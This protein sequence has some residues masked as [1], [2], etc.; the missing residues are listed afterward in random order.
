M[1][2]SIWNLPENLL[3]ENYRE[4]KFTNNLEYWK[5]FSLDELLYSSMVVDSP[6]DP[7]PDFDLLDEGLIQTYPARVMRNY[8]LNNF[9][10][11]DPRQVRIIKIPKGDEKVAFEGLSVFL[12][13][14]QRNGKTIEGMMKTGGY[15]LAKEEVKSIERQGRKLRWKNLV[16]T[17]DF[18][19][20]RNMDDVS[21]L[22]HISPKRYEQ[23]ILENGFKPYSRNTVYKYP[24]RVYFFKGN[25]SES[26]ILRFGKILYQAAPV[27]NPKYVDNEAYVLYKINITTLIGYRF[28]S[29][30]DWGNI[31]VYSTDTIPASTIVSRKDIRYKPKPG[32]KAYVQ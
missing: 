26:D 27:K 9:K 18:Q 24:D 12:P 20:P 17:P 28:Y 21:Y 32:V 2:K 7:Y 3:T 1:E 19:R 25:L 14:L 23:S 29:D 11:I 8:V 16:F 13:D 10:E 4:Y 6:L 30:P 5:I 22:W 31:A 15:T